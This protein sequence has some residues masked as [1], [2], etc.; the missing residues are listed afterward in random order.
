MDQLNPYETP[1][2]FQL[3]R[4]EYLFGV[5]VVTGLMIA[6]F[7]E[8]RW[9]VVVAGFFYID[10]IGYLPGA[11][12][13]KKAN[14]GPVPKVYYVLYNVMHSFITQGAVIL[15]WCLT[16]G[17]EWALL[18]IPF[19]LFGDRGLFGNFMKPFGLPF[20]PEAQPTYQKMLDDLGID[21]KAPAGHGQKTAES[22]T[23]QPAS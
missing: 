17:P 7:S 11:I 8:L 14:G 12:A 18:I 15:L 4:A 21:Q 6:N 3:H 10:V 9:W 20:E 5:A 22:P 13:Y 23:P 1:K 16:I 2:T 19:H